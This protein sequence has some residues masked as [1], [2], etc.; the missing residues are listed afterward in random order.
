M[1]D[2]GTLS[3]KMGQ[4]A[5]TNNRYESSIVKDMTLKRQPSVWEQM[6]TYMYGKSSD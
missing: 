1:S 5:N 2:D 6:S 4:T 3:V